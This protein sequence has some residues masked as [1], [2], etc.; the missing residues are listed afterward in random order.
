[1]KKNL[2]YMCER[3]RQ[4]DRQ[5]GGRTD[6]HYDGQTDRGEIEREF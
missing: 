2:E 5:A 1:M 3:K 6:G 4:T